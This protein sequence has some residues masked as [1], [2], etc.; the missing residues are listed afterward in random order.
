MI[1]L[2]VSKLQ[3][4]RKG[5]DLMGLLYHRC[6]APLALKFVGIRSLIFFMKDI[7][8]YKVPSKYARKVL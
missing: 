1:I 5:K 4:G 8:K 7:Y 2:L 6:K 3:G